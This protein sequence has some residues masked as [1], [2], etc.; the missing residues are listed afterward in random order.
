MKNILEK[1]NERVEALV[2]KCLAAAVSAAKNNVSDEAKAW[3]TTDY[4]CRFFYALVHKGQ[5][6][7]P[8]VEKELEKIAGNLGAEALKQSQGNTILA[9]HAAAASVVINCKPG[10]RFEDWCN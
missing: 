8:T 7:T 1:A 10:E 2:A 3:W 9:S 5:D 4:R 6:L